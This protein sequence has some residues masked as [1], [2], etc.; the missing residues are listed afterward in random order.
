MNEQEFELIK[1]RAAIYSELSKNTYYTQGGGDIIAACERI[2]KW[3]R[4]GNKSEIS[5]DEW[6]KKVTKVNKGK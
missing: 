2:Y 5:Q 3:I 1:I 6:L 4:A